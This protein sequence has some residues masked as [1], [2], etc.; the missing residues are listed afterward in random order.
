MKII[1]DSQIVIWRMLGKYPHAPVGVCAPV[2]ADCLS[3]KA[4]L[5]RGMVTFEWER[6]ES[7]DECDSMCTLVIEEHIEELAARGFVPKFGLFY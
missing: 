5:P 1:G 2:A 7:N 6:R 4:M 3:L